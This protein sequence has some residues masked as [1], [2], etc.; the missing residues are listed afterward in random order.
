M[1]YIVAGT[2]IVV[3]FFAV[4]IVVCVSV[5]ASRATEYWREN[6]HSTKRGTLT[7]VN[8]R[9]S[10]TTTHSCALYYCDG[11]CMH[12]LPMVIAVA[13]SLADT[14]CRLQNPYSVKNINL[15]SS[16]HQAGSYTRRVVSKTTRKTKPAVVVISHF[17]NW[18]KYTGK[19]E[20]EA[21]TETRR[22]VKIT[23]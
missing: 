11:M 21:E 1:C 18:R 15:Y 5:C 12:P 19:R 16:T 9:S 22:A 3:V 8:S 14:H 13:T 23:P 6:T 20:R 4:I 17:P 10:D 2:E 7:G